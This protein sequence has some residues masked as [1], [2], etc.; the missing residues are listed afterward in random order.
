M[1]DIATP[2]QARTV[3]KLAI[4]VGMVRRRTYRVWTGDGCSI[5]HLNSD[6]AVLVRLNWI[7]VLHQR[8]YRER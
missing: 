3:P 4:A 2:L 1:T 5:A 6:L 8:T 7:K